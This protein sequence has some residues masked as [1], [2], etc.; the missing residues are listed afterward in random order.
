MRA[1][2]LRAAAVAAVLLSVAGCGA[3]DFGDEPS[4]YSSNWPHADPTTSKSSSAAP[5]DSASASAT[6][7]SS[8]SAS[9]NSLGSLPERVGVYRFLPDYEQDPGMTG[10]ELPG[11]T[12]EV[13]V[14]GTSADEV[15]F[16]M[17]V[18]RGS[19]ADIRS[20][21]TYYRKQGGQKSG[22]STCDRQPAPGTFTVCWRAG[23][24]RLVVI[25]DAD[26]AS[27]ESVSRLVNEAWTSLS[28]S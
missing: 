2:P 1:S 22:Q 4:S 6:P 18:F 15:A 28:E 27:R 14:Y 11:P 23:T 5:S 25:T 13:G 16:A 26:A 17:S 21:A 10:A 3:P 12:P 19:A 24:D 8:A 20:V 9:S 7:K